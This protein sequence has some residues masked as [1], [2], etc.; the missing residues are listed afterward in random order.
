MR[1]VHRVWENLLMTLHMEV[2]E[3]W[4]KFLN[5]F[6]HYSEGIP[7]G[8]GILLFGKNCMAALISS[9][10]ECLETSFLDLREMRWASVAT[11]CVE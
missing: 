4:S 2:T 6:L 9:T 11:Y 3:S 10:V 1:L 5:V 8:Q 7:S